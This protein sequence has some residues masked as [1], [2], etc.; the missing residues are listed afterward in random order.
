MFDPISNLVPR[1]LNKHHLTEPVAGAQVVS[2]WAI[3]LHPH[4]SSS[5]IA[6]TKALHVKERILY[7][8]VVHT[9]IAQEIQLKKESILTDLNAPFDD[10]RVTDF[11]FR[12]TQELE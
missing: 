10:V 5:Q 8:Q 11:R 12:V 3:A 2:R 4:F 1:L 9:A 7:I 6:S